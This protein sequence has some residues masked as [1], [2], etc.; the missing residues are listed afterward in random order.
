MNVG[1][2]SEITRD[3]S[4]ALDLRYVGATESERVI[5]EGTAGERVYEEKSDAVFSVAGG[6]EW[7]MRFATGDIPL[8][9]G[10]FSRPR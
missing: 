10:F 1:I 8:R 9:A 2:F 6:V 7:R 3:V 4:G 5:H